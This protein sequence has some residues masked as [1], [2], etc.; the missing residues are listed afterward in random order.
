MLQP[1]FWY[2]WPRQSKPYLSVS[3][4]KSCKAYRWK[5]SHFVCLRFMI[6]TS[7]NWIGDHS[8]SEDVRAYFFRL[9][10]VLTVPS[11]FFPF[12]LPLISLGHVLSLP[13]CPMLRKG[14]S[15]HDE[16]VVASSKNPSC[17][18]HLCSVSSLP[19]LSNICNSP[20]FLVSD[21]G[22]FTKPRWRHAYL[23]TVPVTHRRPR[24]VL[25]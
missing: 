19:C 7:Y 2:H 5:D 3:R 13:P 16:S 12:P 14:N 21:H 10:S 17:Q 9:L 20:R 11:I 4:T 1:F 15:E 22:C 24:R 18:S 6:Y 25:S 23:L 8:A